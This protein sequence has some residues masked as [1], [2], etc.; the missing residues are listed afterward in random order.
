[1]REDLQRIVD[2]EHQAVALGEIAGSAREI[3][4]NI[5]EIMGTMPLSEK[6]MLVRQLV[7]RVWLDGGNRLSVD[8]VVQG[9]I[10]DS[11][12]VRPH[13]SGIARL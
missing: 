9:L 2:R 4:E 7:E 6:K 1:M 3:A 13:T 5:K 10:S 12:V 8:C 11:R